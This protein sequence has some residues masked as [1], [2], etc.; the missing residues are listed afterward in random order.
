MELIKENKFAWQ[1]DEVN[2]FLKEGENILF[3]D[4]IDHWKNGLCRLLNFTEEKAKEWVECIAIYSYKLYSKPFNTLSKEEKYD[5]MKT[6]TSEYMSLESL[7]EENIQ[8]VSNVY[9]IFKHKADCFYSVGIGS[10]DNFAV[11]GSSKNFHGWL[12]NKKNPFSP[13]E[14]ILYEKEY[15]DGNLK[16]TGYGDYKLQKEWRLEK[17]TRQFKQLR[18]VLDFIDYK[19]LNSPKL[20]DIGSGYGYFRKAVDDANWSHD[21]LEVSKYAVEIAKKEFGFETYNSLLKD[22]QKENQAK[23]DFVTLWDTVEHLENPLDFLGDLSK[24][25][26]VGGVCFIRTPNINAIEREI[27]GRYY[28]SFK[29]EHLQYFS[30][31][32]LIML[33]EESGFESV[34]LTSESHLLKGFFENDLNFYSK[35]LKGSDLFM[36]AVKKK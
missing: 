9:N 34:F 13:R 20:L 33:F 2:I 28:H 14:Q 32:S 16:D 26:K 31:E 22:F 3:L 29:K 7:D 1:T 12:I 23:Y 27:F 17:S 8:D 24:I 5:A 21:G 35:L 6:A 19:I 11:V 15:Y 36:A 4:S 18:A 10:D 30:P 25:L